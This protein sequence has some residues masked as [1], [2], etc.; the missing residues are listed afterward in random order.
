MLDGM[1]R[2]G[3]VIHWF[4]AGYLFGFLMIAFVIIFITL[5]LRML[6]TIRRDIAGGTE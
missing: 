6:L 2:E 3:A 1:S 4:K 5:L